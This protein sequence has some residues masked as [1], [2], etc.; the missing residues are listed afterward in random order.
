[1]DTYDLEE[2]ILELLIFTADY[3]KEGEAVLESYVNQSGRERLIGAYLTQVAYGVFVKE[4][5]MSPFIRSRLEYAYMNGWP[6]NQVCRLALLQE[7]S[8][9]RSEAGICRNGAEDPGGMCEGQPCFW[10]FPKT[11]TGTFESI[12]AG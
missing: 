5:T 4:Y 9:K 8:G 1:M 6:L 7:I 10:I 3:R 12:S 11:F 2:R